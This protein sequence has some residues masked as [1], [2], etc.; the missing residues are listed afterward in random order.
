M[1][2]YK[3]NDMKLAKKLQL[4]AHKYLNIFKKY[5]GNI[6]AT[7]AFMILIGVEVGPPRLPNMP[8]SNE[9]MMS[10]KTDLEN[11]GFFDSN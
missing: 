5:G 3:N 6:A 11:A 9:E 4:E 8:L 10:L 7:K 2:A 1:E